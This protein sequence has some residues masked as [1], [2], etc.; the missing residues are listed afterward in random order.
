MHLV[1]CHLADGSALRAYEALQARADGEVECV[2]VESLCAGLAWEHR[3]GPTATRFR[4]R[5]ADGRV[6]DGDQIASVLNRVHSV[7]PVGLDLAV[8][9]DGQYAVQEFTAFFL[10]WL[11]GLDAVTV[12]EPTP[13]GLAGR[14]RTALEW[15]WLARQVGL[16]IVPRLE[17]APPAP[18][19]AA[20]GPAGGWTPGSVGVHVVGDRVVGPALEDRVL[21]GCRDLARRAG[22]GLLGV[23]LEP[24]PLGVAFVGATPTPHLPV[25]DE[26]FLDALCELLGVR[27]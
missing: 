12:N 17:R 7:A 20:E 8:D 24:T 23:S 9:D 4:V 5:L 10:S 6:L 3:L 22:V 13:Q 19:H 21:D 15:T 1:V 27:G 14:W 2:T 18:D 11:A 16:P 26:A 25:D